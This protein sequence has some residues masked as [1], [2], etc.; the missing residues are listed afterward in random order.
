MLHIL[1]WIASSL[2]KTIGHILS[3][4]LRLLGS[5]EGVVDHMLQPVGD[6]C[7]LL[8]SVGDLGGMFL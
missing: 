7:E 5:F 3:F 8:G 2:F 1:G 6:C 4:C